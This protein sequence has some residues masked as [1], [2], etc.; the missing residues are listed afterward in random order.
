MGEEIHKIFPVHCPV[1]FVHFKVHKIKILS[2]G[3]FF[4]KSLWKYLST[5]YDLKRN[6]AIKYPSYWSKSINRVKPVWSSKGCQTH[7]FFATHSRHSKQCLRHPHTVIPR[8][9]FWSRLISSR[10]NQQDHPIDWATKGFTVPKILWVDDRSKVQPIDG[11][12]AASHSLP[13]FANG[14]GRRSATAFKTKRK[15]SSTQ[16]CQIKTASMTP[17]SLRS[18]VEVFFSSFKVYSWNEECHLERLLSRGLQMCQR[19]F[20]RLCSRSLD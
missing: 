2:S 3:P 12:I 18:A 4:V 16:K 11:A 5:F 14:G 1:D 6:K 17:A 8:R 20:Y 7:T 15:M 19:W 9:G 10:S 13:H